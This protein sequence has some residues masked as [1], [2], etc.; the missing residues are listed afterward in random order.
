MATKKVYSIC[1]MC[2]VRCHIEVDVDGD[3]V[4]WIEGNRKT[5]LEG[6]LC[7]RGGAGKALLYDNERPQYPMI[8]VGKRGEGK[9]RQATWDEAFDY[10]AEKLKAITEANGP[11]SILWSDRGGP[12]PDLHKAFVKSLGSPNYCNH[13]VAC[14][15]NVQHAANSVTGMGR[16]GVAYD[17]KNAKHVVTQTRNI[18]E[19]INVSE[20]RALNSAIRNGCKLSVI[21]IRATVT[22]SKA[23]NFFLVRPGSDYAFNLAV[24][25]VLIYQN[26]Y[27]AEYVKMHVKD[28]DKLVA[29]IQPYT[30]E[31]AEKETGIEAGRIVKFTQE[32]AQAAPKVIW[33]PGWNTARYLD[34]FYVSRTAYLINAL[35]GSIGAKGGLPF[36]N[37]AGDVG[38]KGLNALADMFPKPQA[39]RADGAGWKYTHIDAG[40]GLL[41]KA[42]KAIETGDP[43][44]VKAYICYRHDP[45]MAHPDPVRTKE[46]F[47]KLDLL[48]SITFSWSDTAWYADVVLPLST[49][50][51]RESIIAH[52]GGLKPYFFMRQR[53]VTPRFNSKAEWEILGG[54]AKRMGAEKLAFKSIEDLWNYQL[55]GTGVKIEDFAGSG[56]VSLTDKP[57]YRKMDE[58]KFKTPSGKIEVISE[59]LEK[60]GIQ[61]LKPYEAPKTPPQGQFRITFGRCALHTQG[62]TVNNILL[63]EVM[64]ENTLWINSKVAAGMG[65]SDGEYVEVSNNNFSGHVKAELVEAIHPECVFTIHGF[66][67]RLPVESR[68]INKGVADQDLMHGGQELWDPAGGAFAMQEHFVKVS[69]IRH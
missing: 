52:K 56:V 12:F 42:L 18:F 28:F 24:L 66:G 6:S 50:L 5:G 55:K 14:A 22:A 35:L 38:A 3:D 39:K 15:R 10:I 21:D 40:P 64:G 17:L 25:N 69:K 41:D 31:W 27:D 53:A 59:K 26:L 48:V 61:S 54:I 4:K 29:F 36:V 67:H 33:H 9:W 62:H 51:E 63:N 65:I 58:L 8:R 23:D 20:A 34:S 13:D 1:G 44:P 68:A 11:E 16:K 60:A 45:L 47:D 19:A 37:K 7:P 32:L 43:Y 49:Y 57:K 30:P 46:L 2:T